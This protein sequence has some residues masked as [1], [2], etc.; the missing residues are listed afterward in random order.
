MSGRIATYPLPNLRVHT[1]A[2]P[3]NELNIGSGHIQW[4]VAVIWHLI[5]NIWHLIWNN[6]W[7]WGTWYCGIRRLRCSRRSR[8]T[9]CC[10]RDTKVAFWPL[11]ERPFSAHVLWKSLRLS[12]CIRIGA[13]CN[14]Y[15]HYH[16]GKKENLF[17][18][19]SVST[20]QSKLRYF[21]W[22]CACYVPIRMGCVMPC[23]WSKHRTELYEVFNWFT[24]SFT[25]CSHEC[26]LAGRR[27]SLTYL[28]RSLTGQTV[29][30]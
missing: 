3:L 10:N 11:V 12:S 15:I 2:L 1:G 29:R 14:V 23:D 21:A 4:G 7:H 17:D 9:S 27:W 5:W 16:G 19:V 30:D 20:A 22:T 13:L 24:V 8:E 25:V 28:S 6:F 26:V 18:N